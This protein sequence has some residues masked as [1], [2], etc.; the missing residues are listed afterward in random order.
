MNKK[1]LLSLLTTA[2]CSSMFGMII[3]T[4]PRRR[5]IPPRRQPLE[6][7]K[8]EYRQ[9]RVPVRDYVS[10]VKN[11][12]A[13]MDFYTKLLQINKFKFGPGKYKYLKRKIN[14]LMQEGIKPQVLPKLKK[15]IE[16]VESAIEHVG[17][18][19][20][21]A[22]EGRLKPLKIRG[23]SEILSLKEEVGAQDQ[24]SFD[25]LAN[26]IQL[27]REY[28]GKKPRERATARRP[29]RPKRPTTR[30]MSPEA[31]KLKA[32]FDR[33][34][35]LIKDYASLIKRLEQQINFYTE[36][37][38]I[39]QFEFSP[40][41]FRYLKHAAN[42]LIEQGINAEVLS[43]LKKAIK[44]LE[45]GIQLTGE[46]VRIGHKTGYS[47]F[48][49]IKGEEEITSLRDETEE[50]YHKPFNKLIEFIR[51]IEWTFDP[52]DWQAKKS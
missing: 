13:Q 18:N 42:A 45:D 6:T 39:G 2:M 41:R 52:Y 51:D 25:T 35:T 36:L 5:P 29:R 46:S 12:E 43:K 8:A 3:P 37:L 1:Y 40:D 20:K 28:F 17:R 30:K 34:K 27:L 44:V 4:R 38:Q 22:P 14:D 7:I 21:R 9:K 10:L 48:T 33:K 47:S 15:A 16:A 11:L 31:A 49:P 19:I 24:Q 23:K 26:F 50:Q 32:A